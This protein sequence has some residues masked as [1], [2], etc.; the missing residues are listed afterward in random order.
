VLESAQIREGS[1]RQSQ[2]QFELRSWVEGSDAVVD[3]ALFED[4]AG[5]PVRA[6][7]ETPLGESKRIDFS[8]VKRG[9]YQ[10]R[11]PNASAGTYKA[12]VLVGADALPTVAWDLAGELF[13]ERP[14][15]KPDVATLSEIAR[16]SGGI[17]DPSSGTLRAYMR[18][19]SER[20]GYAHELLVAALL[21]FFLEILI[22]LFL[23]PR[24]SKRVQV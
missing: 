22:R 2:L 5:K 18:Q 20:R 8:A 15:R 14:H 16:R 24:A 1:K 13:G 3:L 10:A 11:I 19:E 9:N 6:T 23:A 12:N 7:I 17:V 21:L 4:I